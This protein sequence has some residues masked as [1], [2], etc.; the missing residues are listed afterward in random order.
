MSCSKCKVNTSLKIRLP[1]SLIFHFCH[2]SQVGNPFYQNKKLPWKLEKSALP[3]KIFKTFLIRCFFFDLLLPVP[4][5]QGKD[6][7]RGIWLIIYTAVLNPKKYRAML[8]SY[9]YVIVIS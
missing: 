9:S 2:S 5:K 4:Q 1:G 6:T 7:P 8:A 3:L